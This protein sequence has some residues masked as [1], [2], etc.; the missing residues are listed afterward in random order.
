MTCF[1]F[2]RHFLPQVSVSPDDLGFS[3]SDYQ[4]NFLNKKVTA[5]IEITY[6]LHLGSFEFDKDVKFMNVLLSLPVLLSSSKVLD[7]P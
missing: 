3:G 6:L 7:N 4:T 5:C 2:T 1:N